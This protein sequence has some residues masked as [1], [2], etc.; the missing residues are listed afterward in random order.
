MADAAPSARAQFIRRT[1]AHLAGAIAC[2]IGLEAVLLSLPITRELTAKVLSSG[3]G[4][5]AILGGFIVIGFIARGFAAKTTSRSAQYFGLGLY[6]VAQAIIF[7]P[8]LLLAQYQASQMGANANTLIAQAG[9]VTLL[10]VG[11][12]TSTVF[13]TRRDFSFLSTFI[14]VGGF[15]ALG[16][17]VAGVVM[18]FDLGLWFSVAMVV[19]ASGAILY[20]TS[21]VLH[22]YGEDQYVAAS[23]ELFAAVAL[24]FWYV[25]R[26]F[27]SRE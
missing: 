10:M 22:H 7:A 1:Y 3:F 23:L 20:T 26:I 25:L 9:L 2:F 11:G 8:L 16:L 19:L 14:T 15:V 5:L 13:I 24:L 27:M 6:I 21:N 12:L 17:I 18:G 4:W